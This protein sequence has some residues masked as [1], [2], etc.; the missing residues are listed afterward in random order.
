MD[1]ISSDT[2]FH[3]VNCVFF[4]LKSTSDDAT[5]GD[6]LSLTNEYCSLMRIEVEDTQ[7]EPKVSFL[8]F[9]DDDE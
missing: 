4:T 8:L 2:L 3:M 5:L 1:K 9:T 6:A 7:D